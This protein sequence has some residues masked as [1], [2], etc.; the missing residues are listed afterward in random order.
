VN[1]DSRRLLLAATE[2]SA[3]LVT[4]RLIERWRRRGVA[5]SES[6]EGRPTRFRWSRAVVTETFAT[7]RSAVAAPGVRLSLAVDRAAAIQRDAARMSR[8]AQH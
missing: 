7:L 4:E 5:Q 1:V 2:L 8:Q 3:F 6:D